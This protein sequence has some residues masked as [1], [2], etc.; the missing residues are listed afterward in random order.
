MEYYLHG[1]RIGVLR[2]TR[3]HRSGILRACPSAA[4][5]RE[6]SGQCWGDRDAGSYFHD[7]EAGFFHAGRRCRSE[8]VVLSDLDLVRLHHQGRQ[9]TARMAKTRRWTIQRIPKSKP[10]KPVNKLNKTRKHLQSPIFVTLC[11]SSMKFWKRVWLHCRYRLG[12]VQHCRLHG[13]KIT[14][15]AID[16][17]PSEPK[18][19]QGLKPLMQHDERTDLNFVLKFLSRIALGMFST[20]S[21]QSGRR[22]WIQMALSCHLDRYSVVRIRG[23]EGHTKWSL[24]CKMLQELINSNDL[25]GNSRL[26]N[27]WIC[28]H[29]L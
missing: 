16:A 24:S 29:F 2:V 18:Q 8:P 23:L 28:A 25:A 26:V 9:G 12:M 3:V 20:R 15:M 6:S 21:L 7:V 22:T 17:E 11:D 19:K 10:D 5:A 1:M 14:K 4:F 27:L 13:T